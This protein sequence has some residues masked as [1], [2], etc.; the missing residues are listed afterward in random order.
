MNRINLIFTIIAIGVGVLVLAVVSATYQLNL[1]SEL[2]K[3]ETK[4]HSIIF[5]TIGS[6][7]YQY[8]SDLGKASVDDIKCKEFNLLY[9]PNP[10]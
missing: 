1:V 4:I 6:G 2:T 10:G 5:R 9:G 7:T 3:A 8:C